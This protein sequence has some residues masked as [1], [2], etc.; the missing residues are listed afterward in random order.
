MVNVTIRPIRWSG[1]R[2]QDRMNRTSADMHLPRSSIHRDRGDRRVRDRPLPSNKPCEVVPATRVFPIRVSTVDNAWRGAGT[3]ISRCCG[4]RITLGQAIRG[5][6]EELSGRSSCEAHD[7]AIAELILG[8]G[9][10]LN[11]FQRSAAGVLR[12]TQ[13]FGSVAPLVVR[14]RRTAC[15]SLPPELPLC[16]SKVFASPLRDA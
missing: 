8:D 13:V 1:P 16:Q 12:H 9:C 4:G 7:P 2:E 6:R 11:S 15:C 10:A 3:L 5:T 14:W